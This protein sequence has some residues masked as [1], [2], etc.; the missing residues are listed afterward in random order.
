MAL[1]VAAEIKDCTIVDKAS[2]SS[3][4]DALGTGRA[5][6]RPLQAAVPPMRAS[7][8]SEIMSAI[9]LKTTAWW[10]AE[11]IEYPASEQIVLWVESSAAGVEKPVTG[12]CVR[13]RAL[14]YDLCTHHAG[15]SRGRTCLHGMVGIATLGT[16]EG[17]FR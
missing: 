14:L 8:P 11:R 16:C 13:G 15:R 9:P 17:V 4:V 1:L 12:F 5:P 7:R 2:D 6:A 3:E 10:I